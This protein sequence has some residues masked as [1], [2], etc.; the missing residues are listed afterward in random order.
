M[1]LRQIGAYLGHT[2]LDTTVV[3]T[4][5]TAVSEAKARTVIDQL[6]PG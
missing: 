3:Y 1:S 6:L 4:H 5:L 2:S